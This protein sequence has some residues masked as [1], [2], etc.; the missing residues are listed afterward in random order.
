METLLH[1]KVGGETFER[2][3]SIGTVCEKCVST[4]QPRCFDD[5]SDVLVQER[6]VLSAFKYLLH[7]WDLKRTH[8][9]WKFDGARIESRDGGTRF[10]GT[11]VEHDTPMPPQGGG[12]ETSMLV[13]AKRVELCVSAAT[14]M[15]REVVQNDGLGII[16]DPC[17]VNREVSESQE[18]EF[19]DEIVGHVL[20]C[21]SNKILVG[22]GSFPLLALRA[23]LRDLGFG[24]GRLVLGG[25]RS[26]GFFLS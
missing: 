13:Q 23:T 12:L 10:L 6:F 5:S 25:D 26:S 11:D 19:R 24:F 16:N 18:F 8:F 15:G 20:V 4:L 9:R 21:I 14:A 17:V 3:V 7:A 22:H 2:P 1:D